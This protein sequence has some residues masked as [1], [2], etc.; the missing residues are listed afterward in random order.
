MPWISPL[1]LSLSLSARPARS[2]TT[3]LGG[4]SGETSLSAPLP[5]LR[6][7]RRRRRQ[8]AVSSPPDSSSPLSSSE[9]SAESSA[10]RSDCPSSSRRPNRHRSARRG[11][12]PDRGGHGGDDDWAARPGLHP[13]LAVVG[14]VVVIVGARVDLDGLGR[15]ERHVLGAFHRGLQDR[16]GL[17]SAPS[18]SRLFDPRRPRRIRRDPPRRRQPIR[19][20]LGLLSLFRYVFSRCIVGHV[21][22]SSPGRVVLTRPREGFR[23]WPGLVTPGLVM[24]SLERFA[25]NPPVPG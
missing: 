6:R 23:Y 2:W 13:V 4:S 3:V 1:S 5:D 14:I 11:H 7:R 16:P 15:H 10:W 24:V 19:L 18:T 20:G 12:G 22:S 8:V 25:G 9:S 17:G 21:F